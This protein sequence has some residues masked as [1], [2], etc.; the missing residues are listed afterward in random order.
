MMLACRIAWNFSSCEVASDALRS[1]NSTVFCCRLGLKEA[2]SGLNLRANLDGRRDMVTDQWQQV[3]RDLGTAASSAL[4]RSFLTLN[5][6][7][8]LS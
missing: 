8:L 7:S 1:E 5:L 4:I 3:S 6:L 2:A